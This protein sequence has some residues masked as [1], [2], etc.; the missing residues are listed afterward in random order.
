MEGAL[1]CGRIHFS[2]RT[3]GP[4]TIA[5]LAYWLHVN[6][7]TVL[8]AIGRDDRIGWNGYPVSRPADIVARLVT[9]EGIKEW[10]V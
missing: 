7:K 8:H 5:A 1:L 2:L 3:R 10:P 9:K 4:Q 6:P